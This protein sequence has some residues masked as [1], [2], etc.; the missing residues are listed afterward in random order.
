M[1][2][3]CLSILLL[4]FS[5]VKLCLLFVCCVTVSG[6]ISPYVS[7]LGKRSSALN[8]NLRRVPRFIWKE[9]AYNYQ[10]QLKNVIYPHGSSAN[11]SLHAVKINPIYNFLHF[12]YD[13]SVQYL[14]KYSSGF[15]CMLEDV[16]HSDIDNNVLHSSFLISDASSEESPPASVKGN[17]YYSLHSF[18]DYL[19]Q[20]NGRY[21][22][23]DL[24]FNYQIL[25]NTSK[26]SPFY[27]CFGFHEWAMLYSGKKK[28]PEQ[29]DIM[30]HN[31]GE[32]T[33]EFVAALMK[34]E[35][36]EIIA[37]VKKQKKSKSKFSHQELPLRVSQ[38]IIDNIVETKGTLKC[39][40]FDALRFFRHSSHE[41]NVI[42]KIQ[43]IDQPIYDQPGCIHVN[44]DLFRSAFQL[45]PMISSDLLIEALKLAIE[46]RI[47]DMRASPYDLNGI[48][49]CEEGPIAVE[50]I[51]G[52]KQ[53][54]AYQEIL[55]QKAKPIR[56]ELLNC[57]ETVLQPL[58]RSKTAELNQNST[59][60]E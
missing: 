44:M 4:D 18:Q 9:N 54:I 28:E 16:Y 14:S 57:Y 1:K 35:T 20:H 58:I 2:N 50:T 30:H 11:A 46:A 39:T 40:H 42:P 13:F 21:R 43:R 15:N 6:W 7:K 55:F 32:A 41:L 33:D 22:N 60:P 3:D 59:Q 53:Y 45:Y 31:S 29:S 24:F 27:G 56:L 51:E 23:A 47:I 36:D 38:S 25:K 48:E 52:R 34:K 26:K 5:C 8:M 49:G 19:L 12:Y 17:C 37:K 10:A